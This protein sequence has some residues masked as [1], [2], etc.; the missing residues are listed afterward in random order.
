MNATTVFAE[1][2]NV[3]AATNAPVS[4]GLKKLKPAMTEFKQQLELSCEEMTALMAQIIGSGNTNDNS[5]AIDSAAQEAGIAGI[6]EGF[7]LLDYQTDTL[8]AQ[9]Q[10][11]PQNQPEEMPFAQAQELSEEQVQTTEANKQTS[12]SEQFAWMLDQKLETLPPDVQQ[13]IRSEFQEYLGSLEST[14]KEQ[15][16]FT[17]PEGKV[18]PSNA[19]E[20]QD[21]LAALLLQLKSVPQEAQTAVDGKI[22]TVIDGEAFAETAQESKPAAVPEVKTVA[23]SENTQDAEPVIPAATQPLAAQASG[24]VETSAAEIVADDMPETDFVKDNVIRIV[25]KV[26]TNVSEGK[27]DFD[28]D[29]KPDF[30]GKVSIRLTMENGS[31]RMHIRTEDMGAKGL[32]TDH[33]SGLQS[34]MKDKGLPVASIDVTYQSEMTAGDGYEA[35]RQNGGHNNGAYQSGAQSG[36]ANVAEAASGVGFYDAMASPAEY[37]LGGSSVEYLA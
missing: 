10:S 23:V 20:V 2:P 1:T 7:G 17:A 12:V 18:T 13:Q 30:L 16:L 19:Q 24:R 15:M 11:T 8:P 34:L 6:L 9:T 33:M 5:M 22:S 25:D 27:H 14:N 32:F 3:A 36:G 28:V 26:R 31:I 29:L 37:Y 4:G 35:Y 21:K